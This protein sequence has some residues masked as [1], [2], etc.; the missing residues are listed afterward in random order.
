MDGILD[1]C[2]YKYEKTTAALLKLTFFKKI[3]KPGRH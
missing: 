2:K 1:Q 3:E